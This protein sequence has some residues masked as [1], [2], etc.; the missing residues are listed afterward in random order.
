M[1]V[2]ALT[3]AVVVALAACSHPSST[4]TTGEPGDERV[5]YVRMDQ[6][7]K[8]HPLYPQ[9]SAYERSIEALSLR[10][11][12]P[13]IAASGSELAKQEAELQGELKAAADRTNRLL[14]E[15]QDEY[16]RREREA[17]EAA[18]A[19][20]APG[21]SAR[22]LANGVQAEAAAQQS[23]TAAQ[24]RTDLG[25]YRNAVIAQDKAASE[26]LVKTFNDRAA[27]L[28][29]DKANQLQAQESQ[30]SLELA[31]ADAAQRLQLRTKLSNLALDDAARKEA[32]AQLDALDKKESDAM[33]AMRARDQETLAQYRRELQSRMHDE[34]DKELA[35]L[36]DRT[37]AK[38]AAPGA[39]VAQLGRTAN[40]GVNAGK[41]PGREESPAALQAKLQALH[42][43]YQAQFNAD[44]KQ[45]IADFNK[46]RADLQRRFDELRGADAAAQS[47]ARQQI[48]SLQKQH[49]DLYAQIVAQI[50]REVQSVA[51]SRGISVV[52]SDV[53]APGGS[54]DLTQD[55]QKQIESLHE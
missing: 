14:K 19:G 44:A 48:A 18:L 53:V 45:T 23:A 46:T 38:L 21:P 8:S 24:A 3:C 50:Q 12:G 28:Y 2:R 35:A 11:I 52:V 37:R 34:L 49:D 51:K 31:Q 9:L 13:G 17:I 32:Q 26:A 41:G 42:R 22:Q 54:V 16:A 6:L 4:A 15:K 29:Q 7:I 25:A 20:S 27:R 39:A 47:S 43:E 5:G 40:V 33:A 10:E 30:A 55:A 1:N 36:H